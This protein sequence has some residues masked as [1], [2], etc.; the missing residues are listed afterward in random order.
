M[1]RPCSV[2]KRE[3]TCET[4]HTVYGRMRHGCLLSGYEHRTFLKAS[5]PLIGDIRSGHV[6]GMGVGL[7]GLTNHR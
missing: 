7:R 6:S 4:Y 5:G 2:L 3:R 1:Y